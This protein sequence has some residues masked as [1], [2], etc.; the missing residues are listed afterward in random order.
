MAVGLPY[1]YVLVIASELA[2]KNVSWWDVWYVIGWR[3]TVA[4]PTQ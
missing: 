1:L 4:L 3:G 2:Y